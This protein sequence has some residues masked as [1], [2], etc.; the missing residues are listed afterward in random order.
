VSYE[1][2][3]ESKRRYS[4]SENP[5]LDRE[6]REKNWGDVR[7]RSMMKLGQ[8][9]AQARCFTE[10]CESKHGWSGNDM[11]DEIVVRGDICVLD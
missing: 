8:E 6:D 9:M 10:L 11:G 1:S 4:R 7:R 2:K 3:N 5:D